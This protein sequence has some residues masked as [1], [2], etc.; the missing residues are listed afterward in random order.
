M[1]CWADMACTFEIVLQFV[2][3]DKLIVSIIIIIIIDCFIL[4]DEILDQTKTT[5]LAIL[6]WSFV[7]RKQFQIGHSVLWQFS[8]ISLSIHHVCHQVSGD[9]SFQTCIGFLFEALP[10]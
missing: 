3:C 4:I 8:E 10:R 2:S 7:P 5:Y 9:P 1:V 6:V